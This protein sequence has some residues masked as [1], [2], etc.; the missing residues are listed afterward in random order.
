MHET[1]ELLQFAQVT[2][3]VAFRHGHPLRQLHSSPSVTA[4]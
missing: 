4:V 1:L 2:L 3:M